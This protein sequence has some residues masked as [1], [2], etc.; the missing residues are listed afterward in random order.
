MT[1]PQRNPL[2]NMLTTLMMQK[3]LSSGGMRQAPRIPITGRRPA[4]QVPIGPGNGG[5]GINQGGLG[6]GNA[7]QMPNNGGMLPAPQIP[8][9]G[10]GGMRPAPQI[11]VGGMRPAPQIPIGGGGNGPWRPSAGGG[12]LPNMD[13]V[14]G[15]VGGNVPRAPR[16]PGPGTIAPPRNMAGMAQ[17]LMQRRRSPRLPIGN[18]RSRYM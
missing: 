13:G 2:M 1:A 8:V 11:P 5:P 12:G 9:G 7:G 6:P 4:N 14:I 18:P 3:S 10:N 17:L 16:T 15:P